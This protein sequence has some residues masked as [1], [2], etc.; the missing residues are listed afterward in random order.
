MLDA[1][2]RSYLQ[3]LLS[4]GAQGLKGNGRELANAIRRFEPLARDTRAVAEQLAQR[5]ANIRRAVHNFS[6]VVDELGGSDDQLAE[7][8][9]NSNA[10]FASLASQDANLRAT[11]QELPSTLSA[12]RSALGKTE[13]LADELGPTLQAL[14]PGARAL[15]P[16]LEQTQPF[17]RTT[18]PMIRDEIR[19]FVRAARPLVRQARPA[20]R[21]LV[22]ARARPA[23]RLQGAQRAAQHARLQP[24]R[25]H[26]GGLPLLGRV[27]QPPG[28]GGVLQCGRPGP[29]PP[30]PRG[31]RLREP[32]GAREHRGRQPAARRADAAARGARSRR[33]VPGDRP[34]TDAA[35]PG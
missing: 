13:L 8:V 4:G 6:L 12:T 2:T 28:A 24:A 32:A 3:L 5:R 31:G 15:G 17:L 30:R 10:V 19:P 16:A 35:G 22:G 7:F 9:E 26:R 20:M 11:L 29:D 21:D 27:G 1:D 25:R 33:R 34:D 18:T 14:R 23:A